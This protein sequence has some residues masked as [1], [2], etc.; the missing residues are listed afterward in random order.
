M[1][2]LSECLL[3]IRIGEGQY[4]REM[5]QNGYSR[6]ACLL[7]LYIIKEAYRKQPITLAGKAPS[8][9]QAAAAYL[10]GALCG[11]GKFMWNA[12][13]LFHSNDVT[14]RNRTNDLLRILY[15]SA[16]AEMD[17]RYLRRV[18]AW[19]D[20]NVPGQIRDWRATE[21]YLRERR[22]SP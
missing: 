13:H 19:A 7:A 22:A 14:V 9:I 16:I 20:D 17:K 6:S 15:G 5:R 8:G 2:P 18:L 21:R 11:D 10:A 4:Y 3:C 12:R 1:R